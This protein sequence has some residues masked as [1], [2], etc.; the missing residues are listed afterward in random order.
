MRMRFRSYVRGFT[1]I[2]VVV[3]VALFLVI[4]LALYEA[5]TLTFKAVQQS[6]VKTT[7]IALVNEQIE[8]VRNLSYDKVGIQ[9][10]IPSGSIPGVQTI[11]RDENAFTI[12]TIVRNIDDSFDGT[13]GG[14]PNDLS[15]ADY[16]LV[17]MTVACDTCQD[18]APMSFTSYV[19]PRGLE[20]AS[21]NGALFVR[22]FDAAGV[23]IQGADVHIENNARIPPIVINDTTNNDGYVQ[24]IDAPPGV[25]AYEITVTKDGYSTDQSYTPGAVGNPNPTK[26]HT[27]VATQ[28]VS[29]ISFAIDQTSELDFVSMNNLCSPVGGMDFS[30]TGAKLIGTSPNVYKYTGAHTTNG[31]GQ[32]TLSDIEWDTYTL[33][34]TD[35]AYDLV[36][37]IPTMPLTVNAGVDQDI[38][39]IVAPKDPRRLV[40]TV[41]DQG[42]QLPI[43]GATV[44][45]E[46]GGDSEVQVTGRGAVTQT[47]WVGGSGQTTYTD[48][49]RYASDDGHID[50]GTAGEMRL[51]T[52][53]AGT[54]YTSGE[55]TSSTFDSGT[56]SNFHQIL[57]QPGSQI[58]QVGSTPVRMQ[59]ATN[60]DD[61]TWNFVGPDGTASTYYDSTNQDM[62]ASHNGHRY[63]RYKVFLTTDDTT[64]SPVV[65]DVSF[66]FTSSCVPPGQVSFGDLDTETY[67]LTVTAP[68]YQ[69]YTTPVTIT[70]DW[71]HVEALLT[72]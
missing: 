1:L 14:T 47:D 67:T 72:P 62:H 69:V 24:V 40:V 9:G 17:E 70:Q 65:S 33:N 50:V 58:P 10:G 5:F 31:S 52:F 18:F 15:P 13:I 60:N 4:A 43:P 21:N 64:V 39:L 12:T 38:S 53:V 11:T 56:T 35:A 49:T 71:Q 2:E 37:S 59:I 55:L 45:I 42:T 41:K 3:G 16:R 48:T 34:F 23:P 51:G 61:A 54:F 7:A 27:T 46:E 57:W 6:S 36:G 20:T 22:V 68:G 30:L 44:E 66:T 8:L 29:Q 25:T 63:L 32:L 19:G 26:P 28:T